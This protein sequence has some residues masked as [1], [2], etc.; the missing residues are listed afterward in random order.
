MS[1]ITVGDGKYTVSHNNGVG[2]KALRNGEEWRE[3]S[4]DGLV[5]SMVQRIEELEE[6]VKKTEGA[7]KLIEVCE[8]FMEDQNITCAETVYQADRVM[9]NACDFIMEICDIIGYIEFE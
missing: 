2:L 7:R 3:L 1:E 9:E 6:Q 5:L 8:K 4:G